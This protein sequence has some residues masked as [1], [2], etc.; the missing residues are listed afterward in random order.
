MISILV[1][2]RPQQ[3]VKNV[4]IFAGLVFS[5]NLLDI[6]LLGRVIAGFGLFCLM[7]SGIYMFNDI[8]DIKADRVHPEKCRRPIA[9]GHLQVS[10][11]INATVIMAA[12]ALAGGFLLD[13]S[14]F[15]I[16]LGY[17]VMNVAYSVKIKQLVILDVMCIAFGFLFRV[18]AGTGLA[19]VQPSDWLILC[20]ITL[21]LFLGFSKRR[22]ELALIGTKSG[23]HRKVLG[24]YSIVFLD[25]LIAVATACT[26]MS[27][28]LYTIADETVAR[29]GT[30]NL[31]FTIPFVIYGVYRYLY[32]IHQRKTGGNPATATLTDVPLVLNGLLWLVVVI[33]IIY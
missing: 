22:H 16:L 23:N 29:F 2:M 27:Y 19:G 18:V 11:A 6:H 15:W 28:A 30:R 32:L 26:V 4:F 12:T 3:W 33:L 13:R 24:D 10:T 17:A 8:M 14:F 5:H 9:S 31:V 1:S 20:T 25:Q 21:S 7:S